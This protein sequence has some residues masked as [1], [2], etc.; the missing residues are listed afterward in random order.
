VAALLA[1]MGAGS[2]VSGY[3]ED[4]S[5]TDILFFGLVAFASLGAVMLAGF[6]IVRTL[7][8]VARRRRRLTGKPGGRHAAN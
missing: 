3:D 1:I 5:L 8:L 2:Q 7:E 4:A 6:V